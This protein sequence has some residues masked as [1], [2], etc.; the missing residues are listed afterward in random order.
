VESSGRLE[1]YIHARHVSAFRRLLW[2]RL[3]VGLVVW[4]IVAMALSLSRAALLVGVATIALPAVGALRIE[5]RAA[6]EYFSH[7]E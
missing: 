1:A 3:A 2:R 7:R 5:R 4:V 6:R